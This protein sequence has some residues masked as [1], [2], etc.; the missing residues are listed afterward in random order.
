MLLV[1]IIRE[2]R[3][4][5]LSLRL[6]IVFLVMLMVFGF[7]TIAFLKNYQKDMK[8]HEKQQHEMQLTLQELA[9]ENL[10]KLAV[11][12]QDF[13]LKPRGDSF[14]TG[15]KEKSIPNQITFSAFN[16][17]EFRTQTGSVNPYLNPFE[18]LN[19]RFIASIIL[20]FA[21]LLFTYDSISGEK[22]ARTLAVSLANPVSRGIM[23]SGK[24]IA[25]IAASLIIMFPGICLSLIMI[26]ISGAIPITSVI[27]FELFGFVLA[28]VLFVACIAAFGLLSSVLTKS[29]DV[30]LLIAL[31]LWV[32][33]VVIVPNSAIFLSQKIYPIENSDTIQEKILS[34]REVIESNA[35]TGSGDMDENRPFYQKNELRA[36][37][38]MNLMNSE[39]QIRDTYYRDMFRQLERARLLTLISPVSLF[40]YLCEG[41]VG[42]GFLRFHHAWNGL[43]AYQ[44]QF[45]TF[46]KEKDAQDPGSPHWYNPSEDISTTR[47]P[48]SY[49]EVPVFQ[50]KSIPLQERVSFAGQYIVVMVLSTSLVFFAAFVLFVRYDVR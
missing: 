24:Y 50:E 29:S 23:L 8:E 19:W 30:S 45:L 4:I 47:K 28:S 35:P 17:F 18:E 39:M 26:L 37:L 2:L 31:I 40:E 3:H 36:H 14:I 7:G 38:Q 25:T 21:V 34:A 43:H 10:T 32:L 20:S 1:V 9:K 46:F 12:K 44:V 11:K 48:V 42:G 41:M 6:H 49:K 5:F 13:T 22:E 27:L 33:F 15:S 16:V